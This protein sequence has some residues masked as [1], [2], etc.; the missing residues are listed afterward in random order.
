MKRI[1]ILTFQWFDNYGTALQAY[2]LQLALMKLGC[3]V[4]IIPVAPA[5]ES[6]LHRLVAKSA[7]ATIQKWNKILREGWNCHHNGFKRFRDRYFNYGG[8]SPLAFDEAT[9]MTFDD[10]VIVFGSDNIWSWGCYS[11]NPAMAS[12]FIG[13]G[14]KHARKVVYAASTGGRI[15][16]D[17]HC[18]D[19]IARIKAAG[20]A[21][22]SLREQANVDIFAAHGIKAELVPDPSLLLDANDWEQISPLKADVGD[23]V[24]GYDLGHSGGVGIREGCD[25]VAKTLGCEVKIPYPLKWLRDKSVAVKPD[26]SQWISLI[27]SARFVVTNSF[28]GVMF[29]L[30]FNRPFAFVKIN[31]SGE[32]GELNMRAFDILK[33]T[34]LEDRV[35]E[36]K[37]G[38]ECVMGT[39]IDWG[40][41]NAKVAKFRQTGIEY[42]NEI[43][44]GAYR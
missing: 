43:A 1:G 14:I 13:D 33:T 41:V 11:T 39:T 44:K 42:L 34:G 15:S 3:N 36:S 12:V 16:C 25:I 27:R 19:T 30:I 17:P 7:S 23:Y 28:H 2:A 8:L 40:M 10:D 26:P 21:R 35:V 6:T 24:F 18:D 38:L 32:K 22:V 37:I 5:A 20:F 4:R 9:Q 31:A 29:A